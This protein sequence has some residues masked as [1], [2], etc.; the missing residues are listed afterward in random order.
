VCV[1][2]LR[3]APRPESRKQLLYSQSASCSGRSRSAACPARR[4]DNGGFG[5]G[6]HHS[7][8]K[9]VSI[10]RFDERALTLGCYQGKCVH[11]LCCVGDATARTRK[12]T[13]NRDLRTV[14]L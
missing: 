13:P 1:M 8:G 10:E 2:Y 6:A 12:P 9:L 3:R 7:G 4:R 14:G 11:S 5:R